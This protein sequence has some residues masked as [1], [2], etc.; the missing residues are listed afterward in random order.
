MVFLAYLYSAGTQHGNLHPAGWPILFCGPTQHFFC[1][2]MVLFVENRR[3]K[4]AKHGSERC[5][6]DQV[7][8]ARGCSI[9]VWNTWP[10]VGSPHRKPPS[11]TETFRTT[12]C[13]LKHTSEVFSPTTEMPVWTRSRVIC[14][15]HR[16]MSD[17][18][19][20]LGLNHAPERHFLRCGNKKKSKGESSRVS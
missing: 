20:A 9:S 4:V 3:L 8:N 13:L 2:Y 6:F 16:E 1:R 17:P 10:K 11:C 7:R 15:R 19:D 18:R 14:E 12:R 5:H